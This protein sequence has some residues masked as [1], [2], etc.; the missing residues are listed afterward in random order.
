MEFL[1]FLEGIRN[2]VLDI[3]FTICTAFGEELV[4][5][6]IFAVIYWCVNKTLAYKIAFSYF[7]SG[8]IVQT[9]KIGCRI[10][11]PWVRDP[12]FHPVDS[13]LTTATG[14][15]FPSAHT[16]SSTSLY[17]SIAFHFKKAPFYVIT[18]VLIA[19]VMLSRMYL[20]CHTPM[21]VGAGFL[22]T[23]VTAF[24]VNYL[25]D[26]F[27]STLATDLIAM[28]LMVG[29]NTGLIVYSFY[30]IRSGITTEALAMDGF[31]AAGAGIGFGIG[32]FI[33][34]RYI[35]FTPKH[36]I[37]GIQ[38]LKVVI[39][40]AGALLIK[41]GIKLLLGDTPVVSL[42]RY[43]LVILWVVVAFPLIIKKCF[44]DRFQS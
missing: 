12:G 28:I 2:S 36:S 20:G 18:F 27:N 35:R 9:V 5:V 38:L 19:L 30:L 33:E 13:A 31:K 10:D 4:L 42:I 44:K 41:S 6:G 34:K 17:G 37:I 26:N 29:I 1:Y 15:S 25:Y 14:Y 16:Q 22:I 7:L 21:D 23:V 32:W 43:F 39:G 8:A 3:F 24:I 40:L 11:R